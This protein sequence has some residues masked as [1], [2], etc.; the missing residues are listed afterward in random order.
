MRPGQKW[1][2][3]LTEFALAEGKLYLSP[4]IDLFDR[5]VVAYTIGPSPTV[6]LTNESLRSALTTLTNGQILIVHSD[7]GTQCQH[8]SWQKILAKSG[9]KQSMSRKGNCLDNA[10]AKNFFGDLKSGMFHGESFTPPLSCC[11]SPGSSG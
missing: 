8:L 10:M 1:V 5:S 9:A 3:D 11:F 4:I 7:Q 2:T 6:A